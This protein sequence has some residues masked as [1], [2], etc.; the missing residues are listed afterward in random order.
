MSV[1]ALTA[2]LQPPLGP[3]EAAPADGPYRVVLTRLQR[4]VAY[5]EQLQRTIAADPGNQRAASELVRV[6]HMVLEVHR[7]VSLNE[8]AKR[9]AERLDPDAPAPSPPGRFAGF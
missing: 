8:A 1:S 7:A 2:D 9:S 3:G 6:R 4:L 5:R